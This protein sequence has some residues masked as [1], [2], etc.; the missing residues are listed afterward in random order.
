MLQCVTTMA[1][2][3]SKWHISAQLNIHVHPLKVVHTHSDKGGDVCTSFIW[4]MY[5]SPTHIST[6]VIIVEAHIYD[7]EFKTG[8]F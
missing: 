7:K 8:I 3:G 5:T 4:L 6:Y 1:S 2:P